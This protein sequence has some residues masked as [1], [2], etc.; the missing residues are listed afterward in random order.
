MLLQSMGILAALAFVLGLVGMAVWVAKRFGAIRVNPRGRVPVEIVQRL[1]F[2]PKASMAVIRV[3]EKVMAVSV[4]AEGI[5][6]LFELD[7]ADRAR[8]I[9]TSQVATPF[10]S[11][12]DA[13]K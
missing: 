1:P 8:V 12:A 11:S 4:S 6:P 5:R 10:V 2:G 3:G 13:T 9:A 7:E